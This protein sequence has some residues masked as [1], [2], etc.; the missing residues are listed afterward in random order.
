MTN[1][2]FCFFV[3]LNISIQDTANSE[4]TEF[5]NSS[6]FAKAIDIAICLLTFK[7]GLVDTP[8]VK[9]QNCYVIG[10]RHLMCY[11]KTALVQ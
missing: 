9:V 8:C 3:F 1:H 6:S 11:K 2:F 7:K 4:C 10:Y 5:N